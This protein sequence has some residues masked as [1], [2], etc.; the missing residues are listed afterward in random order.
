MGRRV[1]GCGAGEVEG[2]RWRGTVGDLLA[3]LYLLD[4]DQ[5]PRTQ[6]FHELAHPEGA[7]AY[8]SHLDRQPRHHCAR[9]LAGAA[10]RVLLTDRSTCCVGWIKL[11]PDL[12]ES[13]HPKQAKPQ[14][15]S[16]NGSIAVALPVASVAGGYDLQAINA[17]G[18]QVTYNVGIYSHLLKGRH[19][20]H[21]LQELRY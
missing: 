14:P 2:Q 13:S 11:R 18:H 21:K 3:A 16:A 1:S 19:W 4:C 12:C 20:T 6:I 17:A 9:A 5:L 15:R 8:V 7:A 10:S